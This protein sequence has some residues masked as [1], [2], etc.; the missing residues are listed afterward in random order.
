[1]PTSNIELNS[2][3]KIIDKKMKKI[4]DFEKINNEIKPLVQL[5]SKKKITYY[6]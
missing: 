5:N 3:L 1:M 2:R 4:F 6:K